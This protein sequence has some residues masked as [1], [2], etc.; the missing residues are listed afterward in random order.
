MKKRC[1]TVSSWSGCRRQ[2]RNSKMANGR[3]KLDCRPPLVSQLYLT[4]FSNIVFLT[5]VLSSV[6]Q[7]TM[8]DAFWANV[9][10]LWWNRSESPSSVMKSKQAYI[11]LNACEKIASSWNTTQF[12]CNTLQ[13]TYNFL[14]PQSY[15]KQCTQTHWKNRVSLTVR[16]SRTEI[17]QIVFDTLLFTYTFQWTLNHTTI[18]QVSEPMYRADCVGLMKV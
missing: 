15:V 2:N 11:D 10:R 3:T 4:P 12:I 1:S 17:N 14:S 16:T 6:T 7:R 18:L 5:C 13:D 9:H 8:V